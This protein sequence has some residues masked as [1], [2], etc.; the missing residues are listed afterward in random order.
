MIEVGFSLPD[1]KWDSIKVV[2]RDALD[3]DADQVV[4]ESARVDGTKHDVTLRTEIAGT[5]SVHLAR[6]RAMRNLP[7]KLCI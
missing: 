6:D 2:V 1:A 5:A 4:L 3:R 7:T